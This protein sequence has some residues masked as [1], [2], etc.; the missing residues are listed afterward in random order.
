MGA[1]MKKFAA[2]AARATPGQQAPIPAPVVPGTPFREKLQRRAQENIESGAPITYQEIRRICG[3][4]VIDRLDPEAVEAVSSEVVLAPAWEKGFRLYEPQAEGLIAYQRFGGG[5]FPIGVGWGKTLLAL[6][7]AHHAFTQKGIQRIL[8]LVPSQVY[9]QLWDRD[10]AWGRKH[11]RLDGLP[12]H[13]LGNRDGK[14]RRALA[15]SKKRGVYVLPYSCMSTQD[16]SEILES[17]DPGLVISDEAHNLR[18][19]SSARTKRWLSMIENEPEVV[20]MSGTITGKS[21]MDYWHLIKPALGKNSP[22]PLGAQLAVEWSEVIDAGASP[23]RTQAGPIKP[24]VEWAR[25]E[26]PSHE[27]TEDV[28]GFRKAYKLRLTSSPGV[29]ASA[30]CEIGV[31]LT[32]KNTPV[33][34]YKKTEGWED[35]NALIQ[36]VLVEKLTPNGD[37]IAHAIHSYK[38]LWELSLGF[39]NELTWPEDEDYAQRKGITVQRARELL[40]AAREHHEAQKLYS[41]FLKDWLED[42]ARAGLDTPMLV[43]GDMHRNGADNVGETLYQLWQDVKGHEFQGRPERDSRAVR[44]CAFKIDAATRWAQENERGLIWIHNQEVGQWLLES[45]RAAGVDTLYC[46]AGEES[47][48][49]ILQPEAANKVV[50]ASINAHGTG[51]NLQHFS[52]QLILQWPRSAQ[53]A[54]QL[55]G[56]THR[57]GQ[58]ADELTV[59]TMNTLGFDDA[60]M[61][62]CINDALYIHQSTGTRQKIIYCGYEPVPIVFSDAVLRERGFQ[63][64]KLTADQRELLRDKFQAGKG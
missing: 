9:A 49:A 51:K 13:G 11:V 35:L 4:P 57:N 64:K 33:A 63:P 22:L 58:E 47:N 20:V 29:V 41:S 27:Y 6:M 32:I 39:Y 61:G 52:R 10:I 54:E 55:L 14:T 50:V 8:L 38:W 48:I 62:A 36:G 7:I 60:N 18:H 17:I 34:D 12:F 21:V 19:H 2:L 56:R 24:L 3:L 44:V 45:L 26:F 42:H 53:T 46:P 43:A 1:I 23:S 5:F 40:I 16:T 30:D 59:D 28:A 15:K 37:V 25:R 31:S